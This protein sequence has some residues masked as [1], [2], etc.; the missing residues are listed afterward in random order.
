VIDTLPRVEKE[1]PMTKDVGLA[2]MDIS[3]LEYDVST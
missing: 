1:A 3:P 2:C